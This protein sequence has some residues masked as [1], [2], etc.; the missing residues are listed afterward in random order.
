M[1]GSLPGGVLSF[2]TKRKYQRKVSLLRRS[3]PAPRGLHAPETP[4]AEV[5]RPFG[6]AN[7]VLLFAL[8]AYGPCSTF[9]SGGPPNPRDE[10]CFRR[11]ACPQAAAL[12]L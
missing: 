4:K 2:V 5:A 11:A 12:C 1:N 3:E 8:N 10:K 6:Y 7:A 9:E